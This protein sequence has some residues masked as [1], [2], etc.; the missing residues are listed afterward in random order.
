MQGFAY[1]HK[2]NPKEIYVHHEWQEFTGCVNLKTPTVMTYKEDNGLFNLK[3]WGYPAII[4]RP[5]RRNKFTNIKFI[6]RF[7]LHLSNMENKPYLPEGFDYK[8]A[9]IDYLREI[10]KV[11]KDTLKIRWRDINFYE[12]VLII[13]TVNLL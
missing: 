3:S 11:M 13:M 12:Q 5:N 2:S 9:I 8:I 10:G 1:A 4:E 6:E 7:K